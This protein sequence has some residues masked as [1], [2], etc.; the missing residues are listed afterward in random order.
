MHFKLF[1]ALLLCFGTASSR[2]WPDGPL[3]TSGRWIHNALGENVTY[4][5][6]NWP[7]AADVMIPEGLQYASIASIVSGIKSLGMNVIRLTF[8]IEMIDDIY[9][10]G[11]DVPL[12]TAFTTALGTTNGPIVY[13]EVLKHNPSFTS[14]TT[15]LEVNTRCLPRDT[16][17]R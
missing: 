8:A 12:L 5:G 16:E 15:R 14:A 2:C 7:G 17:R 10:N 11:A 9:N 3:V 1:S 6:V 4:A 13:A